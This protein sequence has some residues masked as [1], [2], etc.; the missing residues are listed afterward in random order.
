MKKWS[1]S[2]TK[3]SPNPDM[4]LRSVLNCASL[5]VAWGLVLSVFFC[6]ISEAG[7]STLTALFFW[8]N[9]A[10]LCTHLASVHHFLSL[11]HSGWQRAH[12][13]IYPL[14]FLSCI[15]SLLTHIIS[16][17]GNGILC[18]INWLQTFIKARH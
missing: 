6:C 11:R 3:I 13:I 7:F 4:L 10:E 18:I 17:A 15:R 2:N 12:N 5:N 1:T 8:W 14:C 9:E 16:K